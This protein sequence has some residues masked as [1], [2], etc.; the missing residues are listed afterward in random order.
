MNCQP[1]REPQIEP[2]FCIASNAL[3]FEITITPLAM[4]VGPV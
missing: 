1:R 2:P 4:V 3:P